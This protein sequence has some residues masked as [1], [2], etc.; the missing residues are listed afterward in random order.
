MNRFRMLVSVLL[1]AVSLAA[2]AQFGAGPQLGIRALADMDAYTPGSG[3]RVAIEIVIPEGWHINAHEPLEDFLIATALRFSAP[4]GIRVLQVVY[5]EPEILTFSFSDEPMAVYEGR[6]LLGVRVELANDLA[7]GN[8]VLSAVVEYQACDDRQCF[9]PTEKAIDIAL[10][11]APAGTPTNAQHDDVFASLTFTGDGP[12]DSGAEPAA[13]VEM[14][15]PAV[16]EGAWEAYMDRFAIAGTASG[17]LESAEFIAFVERAERGESQASAGVFAGR[18]VWM[19]LALT[20]IGGLLLNLTPCVLPM[21]PINIAVIG[22][23]AAGGR[24][25]GVALGATYGVAIALVYGL[26]GAIVV[27]TTGTFGALNASPWFNGAIAVIFVAL[28]LAMFDVWNLDFTRFQTRLGRP[29][30]G[31]KGSFAV[32]FFMGGIAALLAGACVAPVVIAVVLFSRDLYAQGNALGLALPFFL[33]LGMAIPWPVAG[34]GLS[35]F[36]PGRWMM[37]VKYAFGVIILGMAAYYGYLAYGQFDN[38]YLVDRAAVMQ[39]VEGVEEEGWHTSLTA[40]LAEAERTGQPVLVDFW[41]TWCKNCLVMNKTT[42]KDP[43]VLER[44]G[45]YV[46]IKYQAEVPGAPGTREVLERF[47]VIGLPTYAILTPLDP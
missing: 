41:A 46:K 5:P 23:G 13:T 45:D 33:G 24:G 21:I 38:R 2:A 30:A 42:F 39:S 37:Y 12:S 22:A 17:Y 44:L 29:G 27:V 20:L 32:A 31:R 8:H 6:I 16:S 35:L 40:G 7:P 47:G 11:V 25:R 3:A 1:A 10:E 14:A 9:P 18:S 28:A 19:V 15:A 36:R 34:A 4:E 26:L 43:V